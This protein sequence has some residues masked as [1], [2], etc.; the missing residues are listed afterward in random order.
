MV[1]R[2]NSRLR[3]AS[4]GTAST[5]LANA[6][7][8]AGRLPMASRLR[9]TAAALRKDITV[10]TR[11]RTGHTP[12]QTKATATAGSSGRI[13]RKARHQRELRTC[14]PVTPMNKANILRLPTAALRHRNS[15]G[16]APTDRV[17]TAMNH[18][19]RTSNLTTTNPTVLAILPR[20]AALRK[21]ADS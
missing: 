8:M 10:P 15:K 3:T 16:T 5:H 14:S 20:T 9:T 11:T 21:T 13:R 12:R 4:R 1:I 19:A 2:R 6:R 18:Q 17:L 7:A